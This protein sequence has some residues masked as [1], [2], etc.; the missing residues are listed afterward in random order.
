M[1]IK[2]IIFDKDGTLI[3]FDEFWISL[4]VCALKDILK[5]LKREDIPIEDFM[6]V[7]GVRDGVTD[8]D[9]I[10][11]KGTYE[12][13]GIAVQGVLEKH[14]CDMAAEEI[15]KSVLDSYNRNAEEGIVKPTCENIRE[16]LCGLKD[17]GIKVAVV[18]T[19]NSKLTE[20][21]LKKLGVYDLF[22]KIYT[23]DGKTPVKPDPYC[24]NAFAN[25]AG[26]DKSEL[27]MVGDTMTDVRFAKNAGI[28]VL[29]VGKK[30]ES[31]DILA[32]FADFVKPDISYIPEVIG[33]L[34]A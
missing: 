2:G 16:V 10:L 7:F 29:A 23:D 5:N 6:E 28:K 31:R 12:E 18:T 27:L 4:S 9:G 14:G 8:I 25:F 17:R 21:C 19:D 11:C 20:M 26:I 22:D 15:I 33:E 3:D 13:M 24:A 32:P 30:A 34:E 1:S